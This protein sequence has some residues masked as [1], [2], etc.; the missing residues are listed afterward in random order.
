[1]PRQLPKEWRNEAVP[2]ITP[3]TNDYITQMRE[4][5]L[6]TPLFGGGVETQKADPITIVRATE[7]RG[8]LRFWWRA[9]RGGQFKTVEELKH[10]EDALWGSTTQPSMVNV[11]IKIDPDI[12]VYPLVPEHRDSRYRPPLDMQNEPI[13]TANMAN[14]VFARSMNGQS[15]F[16][17]NQGQIR[18]L[19]GIGDP[20]SRDSYVAFALK[21]QSGVLLEGVKFVLRIALPNTWP[22]GNIITYIGTPIQ[23][24]AAALWAWETF[25]G[26]GAR[27]RRGCGAIRRIATDPILAVLDTPLPSAPSTV[28]TWVT[29]WITKHIVNGS[30][31]RIANVPSLTQTSE[32]ALAHTHSSSGLDAWRV[33]TDGLRRFRQQR[34]GNGQGK[35][36]WPEPDATRMCARTY[37]IDP[38]NPAHNHK[39]GTG[40]IAFPRAAFGLPINFQFKAD[41][42]YVDPQDLTLGLLSSPEPP[43][44]NTLTG[45][46]KRYERYTSPL[47]IRPVACANGQYTGLALLLNETELPP[48]K[49]TTQTGHHSVV[50]DMSQTDAAKVGLRNSRNHPLAFKV[51][52]TSVTAQDVVRTFLEYVKGL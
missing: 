7:V 9:T 16:R 36:R 15:K 35:N 50:A 29:E 25:G 24:V 3:K 19:R 22:K 6:I 34:P 48:L 49:L 44:T 27:T 47:I 10:A 52:G 5:E 23:E 37:Y 1:M 40:P 38:A 14:P 51:T 13:S 2:D 39:P 46:G 31:A 17:N 32:F 43:G 28:A 11:E 42:V 21:D 26:I 41:Q 20:S 18:M 30:A 12:E 33:L 4:Y 45:D 8:Q